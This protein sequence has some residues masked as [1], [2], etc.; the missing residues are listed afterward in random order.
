M[1]GP[2]ARCTVPGSDVHISRIAFGAARLFAGAELRAS[3]GLIEAALAVGITHFDT[4][5]AYGDG[6][7]ELV[8]GAALAGVHGAT[9]ASKVGLPGAPAA[10]PSVLSVAYRRW[11]RPALAQFPAAKAKLLKLRRQRSATHVPAPTP[12]ELSADVV[13]RSVELS[14]GRLRRDCLDILL[15]HEPDGIVIDDRLHAV[16]DD[17]RREGVIRAFGL[18]YGR[19]VAAPPEFGSVLQCAHQTADLALAPAGRLTIWHGVLR[20]PSNGE[21]AHAMVQAALTSNPTAA[22][23]FSASSARQIAN[24]VKG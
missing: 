19:A 18:G 7:S 17:L 20:K 11:V 16:F 15:L 13:R 4:A 8:L 10:P 12:R 21:A 2:L 22:V 5:A 6:Q 14:L 23:L 9:I 1:S 24:L 3:V